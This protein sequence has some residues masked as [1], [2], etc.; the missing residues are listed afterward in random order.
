MDVTSEQIAVLL[1]L[2]Q[3]D[4]DLMKQKKQLE[5]L[6][7]RALILEAREKKAGIVEKQAKLSALKREASK[8]LTRVSDEDASLVKK[9]H[10]VQAAIEAAE[11]NYR[12]IEARTKELNGIAKRRETLSE[13]L[14]KITAE[15]SKIEDLEAQVALVLEDVASKE[16]AAIESFKREGGAL[17]MNIATLEE[18]GAD[19]ASALPKSLLDLYTK[20]ASRTAGVAVAR[21]DG[22]RCGAC[23]NVIE[24]GRLIDLKQQAPL[25]TCPNCKRLL[26]IE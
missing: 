7:Q 23:R 11:G 10:G 20:T 22:S 6:P 15:I 8:K 21:F 14:D 24:G 26:I 13:E 1:Q 17:K 18:Q 4:L 19:L 12:N 3:V 25:G 2:Q 5:E 9:Q 16:N